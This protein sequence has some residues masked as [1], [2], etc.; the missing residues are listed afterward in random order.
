LPNFPDRVSR[1]PI[2]KELPDSLKDA[3]PTVEQLEAELNTAAAVI[4]LPIQS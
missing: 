1:H 3:L 2:G 4:E